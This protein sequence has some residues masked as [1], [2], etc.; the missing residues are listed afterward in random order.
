MVF[1]VKDAPRLMREEKR[2][3]DGTVTGRY[4]YTDPFGVFR[5]VKYVSGNG[6]YYATE[7]IGDYVT[8]STPQYY[9]ATAPQMEGVSEEP[10]N[11]SVDLAT[12]FNPPLYHPEAHTMA[13]Y[14]RTTAT[15]NSQSGTPDQSQSGSRG[16]FSLSNSEDILERKYRQRKQLERN[17]RQNQKPTQ[18]PIRDNSE[19]KQTIE[20]RVGLLRP[21]HR[22]TGDRRGVERS[23]TIRTNIDRNIGNTDAIKP[24]DDN[25]GNNE[26]QRRSGLQSTTGNYKT[27]IAD[28]YSQNATKTDISHGSKL[29]NIPDFV[30]LNVSLN[31]DKDK[32][33]DK[34]SD[35]NVTEES[36]ESTTADKSSSFNGVTHLYFSPTRSPVAI[37]STARPA[38]KID[39][40][41]NHQN[42]EQKTLWSKLK[43]RFLYGSSSTEP[44]MPS[45]TTEIPITTTTNSLED[46]G[47]NAT[48]NGIFDP[49]FLRVD[50]G[51]FKTIPLELSEEQEPKFMDK[52]YFFGDRSLIKNEP[53]RIEQNATEDNIKVAEDVVDSQKNNNVISTVVNNT[54]FNHD[55]AS[56]VDLTRENAPINETTSHP[57]VSTTTE[58]SQT[59]IQLLIGDNKEDNSSN[60][61][62][63]SAFFQD[64]W[65]SQIVKDHNLT[66]IQTIIFDEPTTSTTEQ[67]SLNRTEQI[68]E[69]TFTTTTTTTTTEDNI[70]VTE[71]VI[72]NGDEDKES[73]KSEKVKDLIEDFWQKFDEKSI[74]FSE[75][76]IDQNQPQNVTNGT[77]NSSQ[78]WIE[79][80]MDH[81]AILIAEAV[82]ENVRREESIVNH[83]AM[84]QMTTETSEQ[85]ETESTT[86]TTTM[87]PIESSTLIESQTQSETL[88]KNVSSGG[89]IEREE[90]PTKS[91]EY[92]ENFWHHFSD[93]SDE[94]SDIIGINET[95]VNEW[96]KQN[97]TNERIVT[98]DSDNMTKDAI[99]SLTE[100]QDLA[101]IEDKSHNLSGIQSRALPLLQS[102]QQNQ[103]IPPLSAIFRFPHVRKTIRKVQRVRPSSQIS[104]EIRRNSVPKEEQTTTTALTETDIMATDATEEFEEMADSDEDVSALSLTASQRVYHY[105]PPFHFHR[106]TYINKNFRPDRQTVRRPAQYTPSIDD[107]SEI[108]ASIKMMTKKNQQQTEQKEQAGDNVKFDDNPDSFMPAPASQTIL[109]KVRSAPKR[110][111]SY[112]LPIEPFREDVPEE[113]VTKGPEV[114]KIKR[115]IYDFKKYVKY[116]PILRL[117]SDFDD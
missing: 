83:T 7:E 13:P 64:E 82:A 52:N 70:P 17:L 50:S 18:N 116:E 59:T 5:V 6:G 12:K 35:F 91:P 55:L 23:D 46:I 47:T 31:E 44:P 26:L 76:Q 74:L 112:L 100:N 89:E 32:N 65:I 104:D 66:R 85:T 57:I 101:S 58:S 98:S 3:S 27:L 51:N 37:H 88:P 113:S 68:F 92:L 75:A 56:F 28:N 21:T 14:E 90:V 109:E 9:K 63:E 77:D 61:K 42:E 49:I 69:E 22:T 71:V 95:D 114:L 20:K 53:T 93:N 36:I 15:D 8:S 94:Y 96:V 79:K 67:T 33:A 30:Y 48:D 117:E 106:E 81:K 45:T 39:P 29:P 19:P 43:N 110:F 80:E 87:S 111:H 115:N 60:Y 40:R 105:I 102:N 78:Q 84:P 34:D 108:M 2:L 72:K 38:D 11:Y 10:V 62:T 16:I 54:S 1:Q 107:M 4:G 103:N 24:F 86:T 25:N 73:D 41:D 97:M 99:L